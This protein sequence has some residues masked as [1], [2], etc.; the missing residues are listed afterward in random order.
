MLR[1]PLLF[2]IMSL[3]MLA[4]AS[5]VPLDA[6]TLGSAGIVPVSIPAGTKQYIP[7]SQADLD[8]DGRFDTLALTGERFS[9]LSGGMLLWQS[10][11]D[12][13]VVQA[14][15]GDLNRDGKQE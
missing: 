1:K 4:Q 15:V 6:L 10:P 2:I 13:H 7:V 12:W 14:A 9:V 8:G 11:P 5:P 3:G